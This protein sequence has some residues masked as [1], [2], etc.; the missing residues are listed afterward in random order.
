MDALLTWGGT[1]LPHRSA[2]RQNSGGVECKRTSISIRRDKLRAISSVGTGRC[3]ACAGV[4]KQLSHGLETR[5]KAQLQRI[6]ARAQTASEDAASSIYQSARVFTNDVGEQGARHSGRRRGMKAKEARD[7]DG[8]ELFGA[9]SRVWPLH[10]PTQLCRIP[11]FL[12]TL[13]RGFS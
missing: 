5:S 10:S 4:L 8:R 1:L 9:S 11:R 13:L 12:S 2:G 6:E 3:D 7:P